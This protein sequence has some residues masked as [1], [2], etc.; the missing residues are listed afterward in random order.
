MKKIIIMFI[1]VSMI[2]SLAACGSSTEVSNKETIV[3]ESQ[4][5]SKEVKNEVTEELSSN[6]D[7]Q[8]ESKEEENKTSESAPSESK[9]DTQEQSKSD[10]QPAPVK[11]MTVEEDYANLPESEGF[12]FE[13][14]DDGTCT[15]TKI[16]VCSDTDIVIP[17]KSPTG[18]M[19]TKV[20]EYAFYDGEDI[21][22]IIFAGRTMELEQNAFSSCEVE[23][24]VISGCNLTIG[25]SAF[26]Y[27]E[28]VNEV[29]ISNS[30]L[31]I[32]AYAFYDCGKDMNVIIQNCVGVLNENAF[33]SSG[34]LGLE[35]KE[36]T[37][38]LDENAFAYC[39][40]LETLAFENSAVDIGTYA[41][42]DIGGDTIVSFVDCEVDMDDKA[43]QSSGVTT[44]NMVGCETV[45]G[46]SAF[47]YCED[48]TDVTIGANNTEI[49]TY[50]F[51]DCT[52]LKNVSIAA[53]S[54]D[55]TIKIVVDDDAFQ[56]CAVQNVVIGR[57]EVELGDNAF[58]YCENL[59]SVE[60]KG[61]LLEVGDYAF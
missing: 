41:F 34:I 14:N 24:I 21:N 59:T 13:S 33:Q 35:V 36:C 28:D 1:T 27:C 42:Y 23:K 15:L 9:D 18:D 58:S 32:D 61:T 44:L 7:E 39:E 54:E 43:F 46:E 60:I 47:S 19:V 38:E 45:M 49:G 56:S 10:E 26:A 25:E 50:A 12:V 8:S 20:A 5:S 16:G 11:E 55:D 52:A 53:E 22:S 3:T 29:Y 31:E 4:M 2:T 57:G 17:E 40:D 37:L 6:A 51:Y 30:T 48:L